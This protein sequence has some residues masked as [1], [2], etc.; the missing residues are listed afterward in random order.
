VGEVWTRL[1]HLLKLS[2]PRPLGYWLSSKA[3]FQA[4][5]ARR[6]M[7]GLNYQEWSSACENV[8]NV[9]K[10]L[11][12]EHHPLLSPSSP[13]IHGK[14]PDTF[15]LSIPRGR[16]VGGKGTVIAPDG[17]MLYD[18]S[19]DWATSS[20]EPSAH[21]ILQQEHFAKPE[22]LA[23]TSV[24]LATSESTGFFHW[25]T[26]ALPRLEILSKACSMPWPAIDH[27]LVSK[28][29]PAIRESL[30]LLGIADDKVVVTH[31]ASHFCCDLLVV[32]SF[33]AAPGNVPPWAIQFL[34]SQLELSSSGP[35]RRIYISRSKAF[36]RRIVNEQ[37]LWPILER[38]GF[39]HVTLEE[40]KLKE[41]I[42]LSSEAGAVVAAHGAGMTNLIWCQPQVKVLEIF[43]PRYVNLCYWAIASI[44]QADYHYL[45]GSADGLVDDVHDARYFLEDILVDPLLLGRSLD[46]LNLL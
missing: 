26:D 27:F 5:L 12:D 33:P 41:Q 13:Y 4:A 21:P 28:G 18:V 11:H 19:I 17:K 14:Y 30:A 16:V 24:V 40:M 32:P 25:I 31:S 38:R 45:L 29:I 7:A 10:T 42:G 6:S 23:G 36:G 44:M 34:R 1:R 20:R 9:A 15:V 39:I 8:R 22:S 43:S 2:S 3:Y 37:D 46:A 35:Q